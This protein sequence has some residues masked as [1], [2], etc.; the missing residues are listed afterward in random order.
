MLADV[1]GFERECTDMCESPQG[2]SVDF[3]LRKWPRFTG[4]LHFADHRC[5][6]SHSIYV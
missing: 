1:R 5:R 4:G 6:K 2:K 3:G